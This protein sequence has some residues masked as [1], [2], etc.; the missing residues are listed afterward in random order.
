MSLKNKMKIVKLEW[1]TQQHSV[2]LKTQYYYTNC[3]KNPQNIHNK[4]TFKM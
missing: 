4:T 1:E 3:D 2:L